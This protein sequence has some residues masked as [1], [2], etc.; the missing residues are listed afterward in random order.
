MVFADV[1]KQLVYEFA[2]PLSVRIY[3]SNELR[4]DLQPVL[5]LY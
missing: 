3:P 1:T 4:Y 5:Y 2:N